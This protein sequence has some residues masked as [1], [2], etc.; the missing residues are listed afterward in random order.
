M[1][2]RSAP[3]APAPSDPRGNRLRAIR[4]EVFGPD[5]IDALAA[6]LGV[7]VQAWKN[8]EEIGGL[9]SA[10]ELL[11]FVEVTGANPTWLLR[12]QGP[13]FRP[14]REPANGTGEAQ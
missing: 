11:A 1:S 3:G 6:R 12:G 8:I 13:K 2:K 5:G 10:A 14:G 4:L 7:T 9:I